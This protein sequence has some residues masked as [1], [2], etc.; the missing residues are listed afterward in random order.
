MWALLVTIIPASLGAIT[1]DVGRDVAL[2]KL[3]ITQ[4]LQDDAHSIPLV[5]GKPTVIRAFPRV[6]DGG[7]PVAG[8]SARLHAVR[9]M[10]ELPGSPIEPDNG[11]ITAEAS[12]SRLEPDDSLNFTLDPDWYAEDT[13][14]WVELVLPMDV[15]DTTPAN[16]RHPVGDGAVLAARYRPRRGLSIG[17]VRVRYANPDWAGP[18][19]PRDHVADPSACDWARA[20]FPVDPVAM[21]YIPWTPAEIDFGLK[22]DGD[23]LHRLDGPTLITELNTLYSANPAP[24]DRLYGW[25]PELSYSGNG[26]SDPIWGGGQGHVVFGNDTEGNAPPATSR[27]RRTF[28]H[29]LGHNMDAGGLFHDGPGGRRMQGDEI[30]YDVMSV[31][32]FGRIVMR[33][34]P[35]TSPTPNASLHDVMVPA[36]VEPHAWITPP[37]YLHIFNALAPDPGEVAASEGGGGPGADAGAGAAGSTPA[38]DRG[39]GGDAADEVGGPTELLVVRGQVDREGTGRFFPFYRIPVTDDSSRRAAQL[40]EQGTHEIRFL[41]GDDHVLKRIA[42]TPDFRDDDATDPLKSRPFTFFMRPIEGVRRVVLALRERTLDTMEVRQE[43]PTVE[44]LQQDVIRPAGGD[45]DTPTAVHLSW[46]AQLPGDVLFAADEI[47]VLHQ[48]YFSND[49]GKTWRLVASGL[50]EPDANIRVA[51]LP[52]GPNCR[53]QVR[54]TDGYNVTAQTGQRLEL[55]DKL[56][57]AEINAPR[58]GATAYQRAGVLLIGRGYDREDGL[59]GDDRLHWSSS[60]QGDLGTGRKLVVR[61]LKPGKHRI[62]LI[63]RDSEGNEGRSKAVE[64]EVKPR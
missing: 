9:S 32:R 10:S 12:F 49:D 19:R 15:T 48:V 5:L 3:E 43:A 58:S 38:A 42:W 31:D 8:L 13:D 40:P 39:G 23:P 18:Q 46:D 7:G 45:D 36:Q 41:G 21:P 44:N 1:E 6:V 29:E 28:A 11:P 50:T 22:E 60:I 24:P 33:R 63:A 17:F 57:L 34:F 14:F 35:P 56:P 55:G 30:G 64:I 20:I 62:T 54:T 51:D 61:D 25:T 26:L 47:P 53:F 27:Y 59:L 37:H 2:E 16:N 52:G 4:G